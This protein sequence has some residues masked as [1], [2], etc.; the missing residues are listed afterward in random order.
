M[1]DPERSEQEDALCTDVARL[2]QAMRHYLSAR[3]VPDEIA[4]LIAPVQRLASLLDS[5]APTDVLR[6]VALTAVD[7]YEWPG[8]EAGGAE[9]PVLDPAILAAVERLRSVIDIMD[10]EEPEDEP[11]DEPDGTA[12]GR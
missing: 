5:G 6:E 11:E 2:V 9:G 3:H 8:A 10:S 1:H 7:V 4:P 12:S